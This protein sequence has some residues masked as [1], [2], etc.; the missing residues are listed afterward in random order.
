V[1]GRAAALAAALL[2]GCGSLPTVTGD[3]AFLEVTPPASLTVKVGEHLQFSAR[4]LDKQGHELDVPVTWHTSDTT[5]TVNT[6]T[7]DVKGAKVGTGKVQAAVG[8]NELVSNFYI[9]TVQA[10]TTL[11]APQ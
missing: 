1:T 2:V 11:P 7:G 9:V 4:T 8:A 5:I 10:A 3:V 6:T